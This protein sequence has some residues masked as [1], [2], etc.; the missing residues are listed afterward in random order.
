M[1]Q[2]L[3]SFAVVGRLPEPVFAVLELADEYRQ[4]LC[5]LYR[6]R[7]E[8]TV[9]LR[10]ERFPA[11]YAALVEFEAAGARVAEIE[12]G[13]KSHH[14]KIR[15]RNAVQAEQRSDLQ[16][17]RRRR[18]EA[19]QLVKAGRE[20]WAAV[21][22]GWRK[23]FSAQTNWKNVKALNKRR[24]AYAQLGFPA[25]LEQLAA[26]LG[27]ESK[28]DV[29]LVD[30]AALE[31]YGRLDLECDL[32]ERELS[33]EYQAKGLSSGI[34]GEI[35]EASQP[36]I[37]KSGPGTRY[38]YGRTPNVR[39]WGKL[40]TQF[41]GGLSLDAA[42]E[43]TRQFRIEGCGGK[44]RRVW[45]QI[46]TAANPQLV[47]YLVKFHR[48]IPAEIKFQLWSLV[49]EGEQV[50]LKNRDGVIREVTRHKAHVVPIVAANLDKPTGDGV[51]HCRIGWKRAPCGGVQ[52]VEFRGP[53]VNERL[54]LPAWLVDARM[55][56]KATLA[57][58]DSEANEYLARLGEAPKT[59]RRQG[60]VALRQYC[61]SHPDDQ[62]AREFLGGLALEVYLGRREARRA[63]RA[64]EKIY[65]TV[66]ARVCRLH[67]ELALAA[68]DLARKRRYATRDLLAQNAPAE[69][70]RELL[71]AVAPGKLKA[72]L[73]GYGL[74]AS[75]E[76]VDWE[77]GAARDTDIFRSWVNSLGRRG[78][79][80]TRKNEAAREVL[81]GAKGDKGLG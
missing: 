78:A 24:D 47:D 56:A 51:L 53:H 13:I 63:V 37:G 57:G 7:H 32:R 17:A 36:K 55:D 1:P 58:C 52:V 2:A 6:E 8:R 14:A 60:V 44:I 19:Q 16:E 26:V 71:F 9:N 50:V 45:Q 40:T 49:V 42:I 15:D 76:V 61:F 66:T 59:G 62:R 18:S 68:P 73:S 20:R 70:V 64:I 46:G 79:S 23:W 12:R 29:S 72:L 38:E 35:D 41:V 77:A 27:A 33:A 25:S 34:R 10:N 4:K 65:E 81:S 30:L 54:I 67:A 75:S 43:G 22:V 31:A 3:G 28:L 69:P 74:L 21:L 11:L 80:A 48:P 39:P 5:S